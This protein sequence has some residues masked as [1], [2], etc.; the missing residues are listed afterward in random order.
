MSLPIY[1]LLA[2]LLSFVGCTVGLAVLIPRLRAMKMGQ[3]IL[4]IGPAWHAPKEGT[5]T[6]GGIVFLPI[7]LLTCAILCFLAAG[8]YGM[9]DLYPFSLALFYVAAN[10]AIGIADDL[11]KLRRHQNEGLTPS[12]KLLLQTTLSA[13][14]LAIL[15]LL[16]LLESRIYIPAFDFEIDLGFFTYFVLMFLLVGI[17]NCANLTDGIDGLAASVGG[18]AFAFLLLASAVAEAIA[19]LLLSGIL[20]G[21]ALAFLIFNHHPAKVFMGDTG[22]LFLGAGAATVPLMLRSP[23]LVLFCGIVYILEGVSVILQ[24]L[25][26]KRTKKR[27]FLMAPIHHHFERCGWSENRIVAVFATLT[28]LGCLLAGFLQEGVFR[29]LPQI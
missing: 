24:V 17:T 28:L 9:R 4:E 26:Y 23:M 11:T 14:Y 2:V 22:S 5:P 3:K 25:Y 12:Q 7:S 27:L 6:M 13:A 19:P 21:C 8:T 16:G 29:V 18:V 15:R 1:S 10:G 20:L